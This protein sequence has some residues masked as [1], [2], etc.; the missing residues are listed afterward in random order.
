MEKLVE[1]LRNSHINC[2]QKYTKVSEQFGGLLHQYLKEI[3]KFFYSEFWEERIKRRLKE[4]NIIYDPIQLDIILGTTSFLIEDTEFKVFSESSSLNGISNQNTLIGL[5]VNLDNY[6]LFDSHIHNIILH[7]FGHRQYNQYSFKLI[8]D[9][10][11]KAFG[12]SERKIIDD[13]LN[14]QD[15]E[16][17]TDHNELRQRLIPV[18]KE[19][20]DK[21]LTAE[22]IYNLSKNL[23]IDDI[24]KIYSKDYIIKLLENI[25]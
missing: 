6:E 8:I 5:N 23:E 15:F 25:L 12:N 18:I 21:D 3:E 4:E 2:H 19:M 24:K 16:Y 10:N 1:L 22:E 9:L 20:Y 17:F 11:K 13:T 7:E 14:E